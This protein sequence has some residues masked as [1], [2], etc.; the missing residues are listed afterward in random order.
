MLHPLQFAAM[1]KNLCTLEEN[2][3]INETPVEMVSVDTDKG[4]LQKDTVSAGEMM[5]TH[6]SVLKHHFQA[7]FPTTVAEI[8][9]C[10]SIVIWN[11]L[12]EHPELAE[13][14]EDKVIKLVTEVSQNSV[15]SGSEDEAAIIKLFAKNNILV[16][17]VTEMVDKEFETSFRQWLLKDETIV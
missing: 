3:L 13:G 11:L 1:Y 17:Y 16:K 2:A 6:R 8:H 12:R 9:Y 15:F 5:R 10:G 4:I 7:T 14:I